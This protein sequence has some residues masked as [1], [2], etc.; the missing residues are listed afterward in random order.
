MAE[1]RSV[2]EEGWIPDYPEGVYRK[3]IANPTLY[4]VK[5]G[6]EVPF[7]MTTYSLEMAEQ[8]LRFYTHDNP[9]YKHKHAYCHFLKCHIAE[10]KLENL[11]NS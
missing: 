11:I 9:F 3:S 10:K 7:I 4:I 5:H 1:E 2:I 8:E 6:V